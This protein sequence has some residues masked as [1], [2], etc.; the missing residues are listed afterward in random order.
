MKSDLRFGIAASYP[1]Y[2]LTL[3]LTVKAYPGDP[4]F[5]L[6]RHR[7]EFDEQGEPETPPDALREEL[8]LA[9]PRRQVAMAGSLGALSSDVRV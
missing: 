7:R 1:E 8:G 5:T 9:I 3:T 4:G 6:S 2:A